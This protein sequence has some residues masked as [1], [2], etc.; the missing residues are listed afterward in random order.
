MTFESYVARTHPEATEWW[1]YDIICDC[2]TGYDNRIIAGDILQAY[3][4]KKPFTKQHDW[5]C[6]VWKRSKAEIVEFLSQEKYKN[7]G[8]EQAL[9]IIREL[10][11]TDD[12]LLVAYD[13]G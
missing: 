9:N 3:L 2:R 13:T 11:D 10:P 5:G 12:Y 6:W 4:D 7:F 8:T 1:H